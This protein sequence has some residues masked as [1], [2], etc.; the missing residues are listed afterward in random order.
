MSVADDLKEV[1][2]KMPDALV[3]EK[4]AGMNAVVQLNLSGEG[5]GDWYMTIANG[6]V[7]IDEGQAPSPDVSLAM[8]ANDYVNITKGDGNPMTLFMTG[9]IKVQGNISIAMKFQDLFDKNRVV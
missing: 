7:V 1:L 8:E 3:P 9:R 2:D 6:Q 4:A 5:G